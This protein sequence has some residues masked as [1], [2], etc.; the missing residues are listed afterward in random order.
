[1]R[2]LFLTSFGVIQYG[3][4]KDEI[5]SVRD[6]DSLHRIPLSPA[7]IAGIMIDDGRTVTL[8]DLP[9]CM[10]YEPSQG[11]GQGCIL[12]MAEGE[13]VTGFL[14]SGEMRTQSIPTD[15]I[16]PLPDYLKTPVFD[17]CAIQ[18]GIP[19]PIINIAELYSRVLKAGEEPSVDSHRI[20][21][22]QP[23]EIS[24]TDRIRFI[25]SGGEL[26]AA[27]AAG[28]EDKTV[29]P[30]PITPLPNTPRYVKGVT[31][32]EGRLLSVIDLSQR[33]K[34]QSGAPDSMMLIAEISGDAFGLLVD[35]DEGTLPAN[36][37]TIKPVPL[38]AQTRWLKDV[39][40]RAG[41]LIPL[42]DLA[43]V[44]S[45]GLGAADEKPLWQRYTPGS[46]FPDLFFKHDVEVVEF[47]LLG[48]RHALPKQ[49]VEDVIAFK[50]CRAF[51]DAPPIV[52]GVAEH[53]GEI[54]PVVDL[55]IM[56]GRRSLTTS[57]WRMLLVNNGDFRAL[58][59]TEAVFGERRLALDIHRAVPIHLPH[60]LMYG[61]YPDAE[62]VRLILNVEA[63]SVH[64]EKS[65][66]KK[67]LPAFSHEMKM[68][69]TEA[70]PAHRV[71]SAAIL[72]PVKPEALAVREQASGHQ[73]DDEPV[74]CIQQQAAEEDVELIQMQEAEIAP[75]AIA[76]EPEQMNVDLAEAPSTSIQ[77]SLSTEDEWSD[78]EAID[79]YHVPHA[80]EVSEESIIPETITATAKTLE[81]AGLLHSVSTREP[82]GE[83]SRAPEPVA[84]SEPQDEKLIAPAQAVS[85]TGSSRAA[86][87]Q[88][89]A[90]EKSG[91]LLARGTAVSASDDRRPSVPIRAAA[92][93]KPGAPYRIY[94]EEHTARA[95]KGG[96]VYG[97]IG[98][99]L[100]AVLYVVGA[101][102]QPDV[103]KSMK[104]TEPAKIKHDNATTVQGMVQTDSTKTQI[105]PAKPKPE[106]V[107]EKAEPAKTKTEPVVAQA[108]PPRP[109]E[110]LRAPLELDIPATM[111]VD[112]DVYVVKKDD[113]LWNISERFT[114]N[115]FNYPR[116]AGENRIADPDLI[117]PGQRIR[118][119][120]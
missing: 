49:E 29:K 104:E 40:V 99:A 10:G 103:E 42:I 88:E 39:V 1:M 83:G 65:L 70:E 19:I 36:K 115:P 54:L 114:G 16:F 100:V 3:I 14:V 102:R 21:A 64:F 52:I 26:Y 108:E 106:P 44:L 31:F 119:I 50:P 51:P 93:T 111:P 66:I 118:L 84:M 105:E 56:F 38:I 61:C 27:S 91:S 96:I 77:E 98:A 25:A 78:E 47:S 41:E 74:P 62:A 13:K 4:W 113:T 71:A 63:I 55:A 117:F 53:N 18:D 58:V 68:M 85:A 9:V 87:A 110:N 23:L 43:M 28:M 45:S 79:H 22:V 32:R 101:S 82:S 24:G 76:P 48:E 30:E 60:N 17:S 33:I 5:L 67:F 90:K 57:A 81:D 109:A 95:W 6:L 72:S 12:L 34:R 94:Q 97:V 69:S 2:E 80:A 92:G 8:A 112:I 7:C 86:P 35:G 73:W 116:I 46:L 75:P 89:L 59:I 37:V 120:K 11:T 107:K 20:T 15:L